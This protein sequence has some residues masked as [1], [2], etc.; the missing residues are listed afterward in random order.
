[1]ILS[2]KRKMHFMTF[3]AVS[4]GLMLLVSLVHSQDY[5]DG[6]DAENNDSG[7]L[8]RVKVCTKTNTHINI[9]A[10][11]TSGALK[12]HAD[13]KE[14]LTCTWE[15]EMGKTA[16]PLF[17]RINGFQLASD[18]KFR[19]SKDNQIIYDTVSSSFSNTIL[20]TGIISGIVKVELSISKSELQRSL[21]VEFKWNVTEETLPVTAANLN[22]RFNFP[23]FNNTYKVAKSDLQKI[24]KFTLN[25]VLQPPMDNEFKLVVG[26]DQ[27]TLEKDVKLSVG[28]AEVSGDYTDSMPDFIAKDK[29]VT[30]TIENVDLSKSDQIMIHYEVYNKMCTQYIALQKDLKPI[31]PITPKGSDIKQ[32]PFDCLFIV[33]SDV[34]TNFIL[35]YTKLNFLSD[36]DLFTFRNGNRRN[37]SVVAMVN[38]QNQW[39]LQDSYGDMISMGKNLYVTYNSHFGMMSSYRPSVINI[40]PMK[41]GGYFNE[42]Q[43]IDFKE[44]KENPV[45]YVYDSN[46][47]RAS[48]EIKSDSTL[49]DGLLKIYSSDNIAGFNPIAQFNGGDALPAKI[50]S[51]SNTLRL[52][53]QNVTEFTGEFKNTSSD[54]NQVAQIATDSFVVAGGSLKCGES[55]SWFIPKNPN[56]KANQTLYSVQIPFLFLNTSDDTLTLT[57]YGSTKNEIFQI[58]GVDDNKIA[59]LPNIKLFGNY[60]YFF[61]Y[62]RSKNCNPNDTTIMLQLSYNLNSLTDYESTI[63]MNIGKQVTIKPDTY[64]NNYALR[65][66]E[67][68][69]YCVTANRG[70]GWKI[71]RSSNNTLLL[72][73]FADLDV[74]G[75]DEVLVKNKGKLESL[76]D[77]LPHDNIYSNLFVQMSVPVNKTMKLSDNLGGRGF[78]LDVKEFECGGEL[79]YPSN[80]SLVL[81]PPLKYK[82]CVWILSVAEKTPNSSILNFT[83]QFLGKGN[84]GNLTIIDAPTLRGW[85][86]LHV[87]ESLKYQP[88]SVNRTIIIYEVADAAKA[89]GLNLTWG[90]DPCPNSTFCKNDPSRCILPTWRCDGHNQCGDWSDEMN[91]NN[92]SS[93]DCP[94]PP[95][96]PAPKSGGVNGWVIALVIVPLAMIVGAILQKF[97]PN[98]IR[99]FRGSSYQEFRDFSEVS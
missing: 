61:E 35:D 2:C 17:F 82:A 15:I 84:R 19:I 91:C 40:S 71:E 86:V 14:E 50:V 72:T 7:L 98:V 25:V 22:G 20:F 9:T 65:A 89:A 36:M 59:S 75:G 62:K 13:P 74:V 51:P 6:T 38:R 27:V 70:C 63:R 47:K 54:L 18:D 97:G 52:E 23:T 78:K 48:L 32:T 73:T 31:A 76:V 80:K 39:H 4:C 12:Y 85:K 8:K 26:M 37:S 68:N 56:A 95:D 30:F 55:A 42:P 66:P 69:K 34:A 92:T 64:P 94:K 33:S 87:N 44:N 67:L 99:R 77:K 41:L 3:T 29:Q 5:K 46:D 10:N 90:V 79:Q 24:P 11:I 49:K 1:M 60:N 88:A 83:V 28:G 81:N 57:Q 96:A 58:S 21:G 53:F 16:M 93:G 43:K 45:V